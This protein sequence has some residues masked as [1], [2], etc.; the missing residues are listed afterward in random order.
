MDGIDEIN[1]LTT[2]FSSK[3]EE[4]RDLPKMLSIEI[5][6]RVKSLNDQIDKHFSQQKA[7]N[8]RIQNDLRELGG[9]N[10]NF[11]QQLLAYTTALKAIEESIGTEFPI[12]LNGSYP[13]A[14]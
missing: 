1:N 6:Q 5:E 14:N 4:Q 13:L 11:N 9:D 10:V 8:S 2:E 7:D 12:D 3:Y